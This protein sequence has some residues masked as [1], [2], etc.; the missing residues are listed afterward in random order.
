MRKFNF[1]FYH[2]W[3]KKDYIPS[4]EIY[5]I[6]NTIKDY[7]WES[8]TIDSIF[9]DYTKL[10]KEEFIY[11]YNN[12]EEYE[13]ILNIDLNDFKID[14][15]ISNN[16]W[17]NESIWESILISKLLKN[18]YNSKIIFVSEFSKYYKSFLEKY[19]KEEIDF[20]VDGWCSM[21]LQEYDI[22]SIIENWF[23]NKKYI[24]DIKEWYNLIPD[25]SDIYWKTDLVEFEISRGCIVNPKCFYCWVSLVKSWFT[26]SIDKNI[27]IFQEM[28][29]NW[30]NKLFFTDSEINFNNDY[31]NRLLKL[32]ISKKIKFL[33]SVYLLAK[34]ID[35][36]LLK[37][38]TN[39]WIKHVRIWVESINKKRSNI[40]SKNINKSELSII[41]RNLKSLGILVEL[42]FIFWFK[43]EISSEILENMHFI[44]ENQENIDYIDFYHLKFRPK[45]SNFLNHNI[46]K[47]DLPYVRDNLFLDN[48]WN[49]R[50]FNK[51]DWSTIDKKSRILDVIR[52]SIWKDWI[53]PKNFFSNFY[54]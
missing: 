25:F 34:D 32:A 1:L 40:I 4:W 7:I 37:L 54:N 47:Y 39:F 24:F 30:I 45:N 36:N 17:F 8:K 15:F 26:R 13:D 23:I 21:H 18:K 50:E 35:Y 19:Y 3:Y 38:M 52:K 16:R 27:E 10:S 2:V 20:I 43:N 53:S 11:Y 9:Y 14:F 51:W 49:V 12:I 41:I 44:Q 31:L 22:K 5:S 48:S 42:H 29:N 46:T 6:K 33:S 28:K